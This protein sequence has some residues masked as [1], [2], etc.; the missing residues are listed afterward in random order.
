MSPTF[1]RRVSILGITAGIFLATVTAE[2][3]GLGKRR[4]FGAYCPPDCDSPAKKCAPTT[5]SQP[6]P[7]APAEIPPLSPEFQDALDA[8]ASS[9]AAPS[10]SQS[11]APG[12]LGDRFGGSAGGL[13]T[14]IV[15]G[16]LNNVQGTATVVSPGIFGTAMGGPIT[17][18]VMA[19]SDALFT[20]SPNVPGAPG[21]LSSLGMVIPTPI[22]QPSSGSFTAGSV[23]SIVPLAINLGSG[24]VVIGL[25]N[26]AATGIETG[27]SAGPNFVSATTTL[28]NPSG[29]AINVSEATSTGTLA[30]QGVFQSFVT[31]AQ[32]IQLSLPN[33]SG[34]GLVGRYKISENTSPIPQDRVFVNY[35]YFQNVPFTGDGIDVHRYSPGFEKTFLNRLASV[36]VRMPF[37][38]TLSSDQSFGRGPVFGD[39]ELGNFSSTVKFLLFSNNTFAFSAGSGTSMPTADDVRATDLSGNTVVLINNQSVHFLPFLGGLFTPNDRFF[40]QGFMQMDF[41][42]N[43]NS[44]YTTLGNA[45]GDTTLRQSGLLTDQTPLY[46]DASIGYWLI[47]NNDPNAFV[48]GLAPMA[49]LHYTTTL[50][51]VDRLAVGPGGSIVIGDFASNLDLLNLTLGTTVVIRNQTDARFAMAFPLKDGLGGRE[52]DFELQAQVSHRFGPQSRSRRGGF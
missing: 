31:L 30:Y 11:V 47:R 26:T 49:E 44:V 23:P 24:P 14:S 3:G 33:P 39:G 40:A 51:D 4:R 37:A 22:N 12:M 41:A 42:A 43:G 9:Q 28:A 10:S 8:Q 50:G 2:A 17:F 25:V 16:V 36:E 48:T 13:L 38:S 18:D 27:L 32:P 45:A 35:N 52:F 46:L 6:D 7:S 34:G 29:D 5:P 1:L 19:G 15:P 21:S 20:Y